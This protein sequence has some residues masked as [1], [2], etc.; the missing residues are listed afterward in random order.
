MV[1]QKESGSLI[2][3]KIDQALGPI[4]EGEVVNSGRIISMTS[5][6]RLRRTVAIAFTSSRRLP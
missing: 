2:N 3:L 6:M 5:W 1:R 4:W